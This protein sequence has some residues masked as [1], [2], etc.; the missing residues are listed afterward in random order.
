MRK[1]LAFSNLADEF[2]AFLDNREIGAELGGKDPVKPEPLQ[3]S[4]QLAG[5]NGS[6]LQAE[7]LS[8][9]H[10]NRRGRLHHD[11]HV[12]IVQ[13]FPNTAD[14]TDLSDGAYRAD[15]GTLPALGTVDFTV[16]QIKGG[17]HNRIKAAPGKIQRHH[18]LD[19]PT[20]PDTAPAENAL[21]GI[22]FQ[23]KALLHRGPFPFLTGKP[24]DRPAVNTQIRRQPLKFAAAA[25]VAAKTIVGVIGEEQFDVE[26]PCSASSGAASTDSHSVSGRSHA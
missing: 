25:A 17:C 24:V 7:L 9:T 19:F 3:S 4:D 23:R 11:K 5:Y 6:W 15:S 18:T 21:V 8:N 16:R 2:M 22:P 1:L 13:R 10:L 26:F 14:F 20:S 12:W